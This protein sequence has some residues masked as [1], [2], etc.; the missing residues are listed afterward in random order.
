MV[1][2]VGLASDLQVLAVIGLFH[3]KV[4]RGASL[5]DDFQRVCVGMLSS[6]HDSLAADPIPV[7]NAACPATVSS[8]EADEGDVE[9]QDTR[10]KTVAFQNRSCE[11]TRGKKAYDHPRI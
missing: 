7:E 6:C 2:E 4:T 3:Y 5:A 1:A 11:K 10:S 9:V 8:D